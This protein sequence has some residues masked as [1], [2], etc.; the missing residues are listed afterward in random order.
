M[1]KFKDFHLIQPYH[2]MMSMDL[3]ALQLASRFALPPNSYGYCGKDTAPEKFKCCVI[4][5]LCEGVEDEITKFIVLN[6]YLQTIGALLNKNPFSYEVVESYWLGNEELNN[7][8]ET[9]YTL[10]LDNFAKQGVPDWLVAELRTKKPKR[11]IPTHL[12]QVLHVGVGRA[13]GSVPY[14]LDTINNC[15]IR[16]GIVEEVEGDS[17]KI[18]LT[19]LERNNEQYSLTLSTETHKFIPDFI[20]QPKKGDIVTVHW[21]QIV[22]HITS[23]ELHKLEKW[24]N[25]VLRNTI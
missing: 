19:S 20:K 25:E 3:K 2:I 8:P 5:E 15:M 18:Q 24:T 14:N 21:K 23:E 11:F 17:A 1:T 22:K 6:P 4:D 13:S 7:I 12:F 10:L 16:W 9:G